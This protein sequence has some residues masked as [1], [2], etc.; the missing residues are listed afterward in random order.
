MTK[1]VFIHNIQLS[2]RSSFIEAVCLAFSPMVYLSRNFTSSF[3]SW[4]SEKLLLQGW[5][6]YEIVRYAPQHNW[7]AYEEALKTNPVL[8]KMMISGIVYSIG[9]WIA[10]VK[11]IFIWFYSTLNL[12]NLNKLSLLYIATVLCREATFWVRSCSHVP[13]W[14]HWICSSWLPFSL[15]LWILWGGYKLLCILQ[16]LL[17]VKCLG[18]LHIAC[19]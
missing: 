19:L 11:F 14:T 8:A 12:W 2:H 7:T 17:F 5:T 18:C 4:S 3:L 9:D 6:I 1:G 15:L 16:I 13:F 10:Q